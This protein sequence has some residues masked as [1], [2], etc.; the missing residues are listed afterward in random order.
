MNLLTYVYWHGEI[1]REV[2]DAVCE[3]AQAGVEVNVLFDAVGSA[4]MGRELTGQ[5]R[6][7]GVEPRGLPAARS[8]TRSA[9]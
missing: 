3:R 9:A 1:A 5:M 8:P 6:D 4:K 2:A 7:A